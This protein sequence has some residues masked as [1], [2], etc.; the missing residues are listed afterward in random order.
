MDA[1]AVNANGS[2]LAKEVMTTEINAG[3]GSRPSHD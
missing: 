2:V 1:N 3:K